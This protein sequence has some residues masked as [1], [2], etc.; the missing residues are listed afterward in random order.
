MEIE[1]NK[2][3]IDAIAYKAAL[4]VVRKLK[5]ADNSL[6]EM[7]T[8]KQAASILNITPGRMRQ[9]ADRFPHIKQGDNKQ[10]KLLFIRKALLENY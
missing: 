9:I 7:V 10:G 3:T 4:I 5:D 1:L 6:P 8:T 2:K